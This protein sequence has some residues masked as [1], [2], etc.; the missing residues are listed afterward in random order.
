VHK[1]TVLLRLKLLCT[2]DT[3]LNDKL[4]KQIKEAEAD[5]CGNTKIEFPVRQGQCHNFVKEKTEDRSNAAL[6][7]RKD[8]GPRIQTCPLR[9]SNLRSGMR[10]QGFHFIKSVVKNE[11]SII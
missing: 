11:H 9:N 8:S 1:I 2:I 7:R 10:Q 6:P 4:R 3:P 5:I